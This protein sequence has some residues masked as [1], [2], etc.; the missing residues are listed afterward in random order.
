MS[1]SDKVKNILTCCFCRRIF[2]N[3][4]N[5]NCRH[6]FCQQ[7]IQQWIDTH[8]NICPTC[9]E[10]FENRGSWQ[11]GNMLA[12]LYDNVIIIG[13]FVFRVD[14]IASNLVNELQL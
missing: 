3:P 8:H 5:S 2:T 4:V 11:L 1:L 13:N 14:I 10:E 7:C 6:T 12:A 9:D